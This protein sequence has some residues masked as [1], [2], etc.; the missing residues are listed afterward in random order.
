M[1]KKGGNNDDER[2]KNNPKI[3]QRN[4][5]GNNHHKNNI[6][7]RLIRA[8]MKSK[9]KKRYEEKRSKGDSLCLNNVLNQSAL[10]QT[11][12]TPTI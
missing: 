6:T 2:K 1:T 8:I 10:S 12:S 7:A 4:G 3:N 11:L 9:G 5:G